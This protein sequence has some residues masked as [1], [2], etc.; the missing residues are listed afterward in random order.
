MTVGIKSALNVT[1]F[2]YWKNFISRDEIPLNT[3]VGVKSVTTN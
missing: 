3:I 2:Y 1:N